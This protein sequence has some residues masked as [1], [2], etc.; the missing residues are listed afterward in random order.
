MKSVK[1][2]LALLLAALFLLQGCGFVDYIVPQRPEY[3]LY[4]KDN[5]IYFKDLGSKKAPIK[6]TKNVFDNYFS[7]L[8]EYYGGSNFEDQVETITGYS[9]MFYMSKKGGFVVYG[10]NYDGSL[11][12]GDLYSMKINKKEPER[13]K[14]D[15]GVVRYYVS[16]D[17]KTIIYLKDNDNLYRYSLK[18]GQKERIAGDVE[19]CRVSSD[20]KSVYYETDDSDIYFWALKKEPYKI[21]K[22]ATIVD[23]ASSGKKVDSLF[24]ITEE[25]KFF[26]TSGKGEPRLIDSDVYTVTCVY[27]DGTAFYSKEVEAKYVD[28]YI[29]DDMREF[30]ANDSNFESVFSNDYRLK[31]NRDEIRNSTFYY[32]TLYYCDEK[33]N[34]KELET[35]KMTRAWSSGLKQNGVLIF[36]AYDLF[37]IVKRK[38][39]EINVENVDDVLSDL[40]YG[41]GSKFWAI[42]PEDCIEVSGEW[43][44]TNP[45]G[46]SLYYWTS[47]KN[48]DIY[49]I[50][51]KNGMFTDET[52]VDTECSIGGSFVSE[53]QLVYN[54]GGYLDYDIFCNGKLIDTDTRMLTFLYA[55]NGNLYY[56]NDFE[57]DDDYYG[58]GYCATLNC[59][60]GGKVSRID[61]DVFPVV[62][63][64]G[65]TLTYVGDYNSD[66]H[67][68]TLYS[69]KKGKRTYVDDDV[70]MVLS[71]YR[72]DYSTYFSDDYR[73]NE[74]WR[75]NGGKN[76]YFY[77]DF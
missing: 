14:I 3:A 32:Y 9:G 34:S 47:S 74:S 42:T 57:N 12:S 31:Q 62:A 21:A 4:Y 17:E 8:G 67:E 60:K 52:L 7:Y 38:M 77:A 37:G 68:G 71:D 58:Y 35:P 27:D 55:N 39:S 36:S 20:C 40:I 23:T 11:Y 5:Q 56:F 65:D 43:N 25:G 2:F 54:K 26:K 29:E 59:Y 16:D 30:D 50:D 49:R 75:Y 6:L 63:T 44:V 15:S 22:E 10:D 64:A 41:Y 33:G 1:K 45:E 24:Y 13:V 51:I 73:C 28:Y 70:T 66:K 53:S 69:Y 48:A 46:T 19:D 76:A 61:D 72:N 18:N